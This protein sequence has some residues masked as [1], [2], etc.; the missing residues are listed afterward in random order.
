MGDREDH[1]RTLL[2]FPFQPIVDDMGAQC[3]SEHPGDFTLHALPLVGHN[4]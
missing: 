1:L 2:V 3:A 4:L